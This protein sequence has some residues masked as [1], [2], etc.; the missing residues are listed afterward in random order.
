MIHNA[1]GFQ[2]TVRYRRTLVQCKC[3]YVTLLRV[4]HINMTMLSSPMLRPWS[5]SSM[6][7]PTDQGG[8]C[9]ST[10]V[11]RRASLAQTIEM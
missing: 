9:T 11:T 6:L 3:T 10:Y 4:A 5:Y 7:R 1:I 8:T 2:R